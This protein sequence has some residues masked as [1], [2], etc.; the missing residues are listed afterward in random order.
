L[1][2]SKV[3]EVLKANRKFNEVCGKCRYLGLE[4]QPSMDCWAMH[5]FGGGF[6]TSA[7]KQEHPDVERMRFPES[8]QSCQSACP[9]CQ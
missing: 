3:I 1:Y 7:R 6:L 2:I 9:I 8:E 5:D 4:S